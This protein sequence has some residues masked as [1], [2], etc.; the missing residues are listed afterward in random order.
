MTFTGNKLQDI[1]DA[2]SGLLHQLEAQVSTDLKDSKQEHID[3]FKVDVELNA[4]RIKKKADKLKEEL[5]EN[6]QQSLE[7]LRSAAA[8]EFAESRDYALQMV[9]DLANLSDKLKSSITALKLAHEE[10]VERIGVT[11]SDRYNTAVEYSKLELEKQDFASLKHLKSHGTFVSNQLQQKLDHVLWESRGEEKQVT[12][13]LFKSYMQ[14]ANAI[15]SHFSSLMQKLSSDFQ[16]LYRALEAEAANSDAELETAAQDLLLRIDNHAGAVED[17]VT[18]T[19]HKMSES[20]KRKLD[21]DLASIADELS[22]VHDATTE[23]L[24]EC[25][26]KLV[27]SLADAASQAQEALKDRCLDLKTKIKSEMDSFNGRLDERIKVGTSLKRTLEADKDRVVDSL[28]SEIN[29]I[30]GSFEEKISRLMQEAGM[31]V[32]SISSDAERDILSAQKHCDQ[33]L[34]ANSQEAKNEMEEQVEK[35]LQ[36]VAT[37][38]AA[39]IEDIRKSVAEKDG[40]AESGSDQVKPKKSKKHKPDNGPS[41]E[42]TNESRNE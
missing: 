9:S 26:E 3:Q 39:A 29:E 31:R 13:T 41:S 12:T 27:G 19:F 10:K 5:S 30:R 1:Y 33:S 7:H 34:F 18:E 24:S 32:Q 2:G 14:K 6:V 36:L 15:D 8:S 40:G 21:G 28:Q 38:R 23:R 16:Q 17:H 4:K 20:H 11:F 42:P 22:I 25:T 35:F 37:H